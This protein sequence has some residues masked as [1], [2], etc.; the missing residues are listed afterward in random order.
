MD[1]A[2]KTIVAVRVG[3][4]GCITAVGGPFGTTGKRICRPGPVTNQSR[5]FG[6]QLLPFENDD[7]ISYPSVET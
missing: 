4:F 6:T 3:V 7:E 5:S 1:A 2:D